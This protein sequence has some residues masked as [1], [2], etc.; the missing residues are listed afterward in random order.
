VVI[1]YNW[2][3]ATARSFESA[4]ANHALAIFQHAKLHG[5][6]VRP[7]GFEEKV[8]LKWITVLD[9]VA[10]MSANSLGEE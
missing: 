9:Q 10:E 1:E 4:Y 3:C 6:L 5:F 8:L 2:I 7:D